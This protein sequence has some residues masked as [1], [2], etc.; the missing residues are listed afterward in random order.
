MESS[1][2]PKINYYPKT[3]QKLNSEAR[4]TIKHHENTFKC[5]HKQKYQKIERT[6]LLSTVSVSFS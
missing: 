5:K 1:R 6:A 4:E 2:S 3:F